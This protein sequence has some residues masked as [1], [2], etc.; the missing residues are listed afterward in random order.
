[1][2][3]ASRKKLSLPLFPLMKTSVFLALFVS[4]SPI[5]HLAG[6]APSPV[7]PAVAP[8]SN[9]KP[10][11]LS[12]SDK[13]VVANSV[14]SVYLLLSLVDWQTHSNISGAATLD[15][16]KAAGKDFNA[17]WRELADLCTAN[18][19]TVP[20]A[21]G[22]S[23]KTKLERLRKETGARYEKEL[24]EWIS[25]ETRR[26]SSGLAAASKAAGDPRVKQLAEKWA[27]VV[28]AQKESAEK[29]EKVAEKTK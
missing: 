11:P 5:A 2:A 14:E 21:L 15:Y 9:E 4:L 19:L 8:A 24:L 13:T 28:K 7:N 26:L 23:D 27:P 1:M 12:A 17:F 22:G 18:G 20:S 10:K 25:K 6:Q 16:V 29:A 3:F